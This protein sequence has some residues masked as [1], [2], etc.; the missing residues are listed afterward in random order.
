MKIKSIKTLNNGMGDVQAR[1]TWGR[2]A[3][4][5]SYSFNRSHAVEYTVLSWW[6]MYVKVYY[7]AE[8]YAAAMSVVDKE[9]KLA[10]LVLDARR[11]DIKVLPPDINGSTDQIEIQSD[12]VLLAPFQ[13]VKGISDN[14]AKAIM[15]LRK[16]AG[17]FT[18]KLHLE[19]VVTAN[20]MGAKCNVA[21]RERLERVGAFYSTDGGLQPMHADRLKDRLELMPGFTVDAVKADRKI[22]A[23]TFVM[24]KI[25]RLHEDTKA[26]DKCSLK[27]MPHPQPRMGRTPKFM[28]VFDS[29]S[30]EE[31][32]AGKML[33]GDGA[34]FLKA[35]LKDAGL[36]PND[37]YYTSLV[38]AKRP[39]GSKS[40]T[41]EQI[42]GCSGYL[43]E[44]IATLKPPVI[45]AMGSASAK[46]FLPSFKGSASDLI[47][48]VIF[49][50]KLDASI[51]FGINPAQV[52]FDGSKIGQL[53]TV[54]I[55][56]AE[57]VQ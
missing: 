16:D 7:P 2:I 42:N 5:A 28:V 11:L 21:H 3:G 37:G 27:G 19:S 57:I 29:P 15:K 10:T 35:A 40:L 25:I 46:F 8:F 32:K 44:E 36:S 39:K 12:L 24:S 34:G 55:K 38:K 13:A 1:V 48:K 18:S 53:Q 43:Q 45:L 26:C 31:E 47:G 4:F 22:I 14:T 30:W 51:V 54:A 50:A 33:E 6:A 49:D 41:T 20:K 17:G 52:I 23:D 9:D 56:T